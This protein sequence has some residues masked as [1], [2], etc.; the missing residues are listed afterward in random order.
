MAGTLRRSGG[1]HSGLGKGDL[2]A[3]L[4]WVGVP[5]WLLGRAV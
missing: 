4:T 5:G 3:I 2:R 1:L